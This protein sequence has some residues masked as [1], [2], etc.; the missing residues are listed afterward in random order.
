MTKIKL[1]GMTREC[2][3]QAANSLLP[4]YIGFVFAEKS[5][6]FVPE[7]KARSLGN[8]LDKKIKRVGVFVNEKPENASRLANSGII[9]IIQLHGSETDDYIKYLKNLTD[10]TIIKAFSVSSLYD[11]EKAEISSADL[12]LLDS[13]SG[14]T[15]TSFDW[16]LLKN[17]KRDYFLAGGLDETKVII[18][19][20]NLSPY[21]VDVSSGIETNGFKDTEKMKS[22]VR[23]VRN[24]DKA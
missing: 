7:E 24:F 9:D 14:G 15:G 3:I 23:A 19:L 2:D 10:K 1:C 18:A 4:E 22:F 20:K 8:I 17:I 11:I 21:G 12:V 6:R 16:E 13:G 5:R